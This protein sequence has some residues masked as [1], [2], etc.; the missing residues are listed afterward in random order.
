MAP[1]SSPAAAKSLRVMLDTTVL[2]A[3]IAW[4]RW[5]Y[6]VLR[7]AL[8]GDFRLVLSPLV[9]KQARRKPSPVTLSRSRAGC[10]GY[11][12]KG[13]TIRRRLQSLETKT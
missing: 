13:W 5:S 9:I 11:R 4:P 1:P 10:K 2:I 8:S 6:E 12:L 7:H 3:G